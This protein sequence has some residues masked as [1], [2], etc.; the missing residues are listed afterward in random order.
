M[1]TKL[2]KGMLVLIGAAALLTGCSS[3]NQGAAGSDT[4]YGAGAGG[5]N[6]A[7]SGPNGSVSRNNPLG[8]GTG[9]GLTSV[10]AH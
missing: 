5:P 9:V 7:A 4:M 10:P 3:T 6:A 1:K 8:L 2:I